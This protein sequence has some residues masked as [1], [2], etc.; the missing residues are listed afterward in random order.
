MPRKRIERIRNIGIIAHIDAGKTTVTERFLYYSG[1]SHKIGEVHDGEAVMDFLDD[2]RERGITISSAATTF[3][4]GDHQINLI[5]TPGHVDFTAEVERSM[6][7]LDGAVV[8]FDAVEG[9]EPQSETVWHQADHYHVPRICFVNKMDRVGADFDQA[10]DQIRDKLG[11]TP[12][13]VQRPVESG[14]AFAGLLD[15][16]EGRFLQWGEEGL[17]ESFSADPVPRELTGKVEDARSALIECLADH[18]D[19]IAEK[20]IEGEEISAAELRGA[21]RR[22]TLSGAV[23]PVLCGAALRNTGIQPLLDGVCAYLPSPLDVPPVRGTQPGGEKVLTRRPDPTDPFSALIYKVTASRAADL[24]YLRVYSGRIESGGWAVNSRTGEKERLRRILQIHAQHGKPR[25]EA[26]AG[27]IVAVTALKN[28]ATGDTLSDPSHPI[29]Y[30]SITFPDTVVSVAVEAR[31]A[32]ERE[33]LVD[34]LRRIGREDPTLRQKVEEETGQIIL[35]GM[36]ELHIDVVK[37][38]LARDFRIEAAFGKPRVSYRETVR[39]AIEGE[40]EFARMLGNQEHYAL[41]RVLVEP[42]AQAG[43]V[44]VDSSLSDGSIPAGLLPGLLDTLRTATEGGGIYGFPVVGVKVTA[45][46]A[47][48]G[49]QGQPEIALNS[50]ATLAFRDALRHAKVSVLEPI[51][52]L[53]IRTPEEH[54]GSIVKNLGSRRAIVE[55]TKFMKKI[56]LVRGTV[57]L[58]EMFGY[59]TTLRSHSQGRASF[60]MEP[61][62]YRPVPDSLVAVLAQKL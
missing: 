50:A 7:V 21:L 31:T 44:E 52:K 51:M 29:A 34:V 53:E 48:I 55:E 24:F 43:S 17:G 41:L 19:D 26:V 39:D 42:S 33:R 13:V 30:E 27:D 28:S 49:D 8:V 12:A 58:A 35:S 59:S 16:L 32:Q 15:V 11:A 61:L 1:R 18:A 6:R 47:K 20:F 38:R 3:Q 2:E 36:G 25:E 5:D 40:A 46:K 37:N 45:L 14:E 57:P 62:D 56:V 10:V 22:A 60:N 9:V 4:W 54:L 23:V